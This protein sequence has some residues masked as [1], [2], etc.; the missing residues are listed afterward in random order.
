MVIEDDND[1]ILIRV[2]GYA[3]ILF[4]VTE[5]PDI[6]TDADILWTMTTLDF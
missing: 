6:D 5:P 2:V 1:D 4:A 3:N